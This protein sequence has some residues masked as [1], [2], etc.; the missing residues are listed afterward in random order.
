MGIRYQ[1]SILNLNEFKGEITI[2]G[3]KFATFTLPWGSCHFGTLITEIPGYSTPYSNTIT[4]ST[5]H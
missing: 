5:Y 1:G 2:T 3:N 4:S